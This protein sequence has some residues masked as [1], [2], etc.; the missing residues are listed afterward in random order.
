MIVANNGE[1]GNKVIEE[2]WEKKFTPL[3]S[4]CL[5]LQGAELDDVFTVRM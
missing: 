5:L 3:F 2:H 4:L 1:E